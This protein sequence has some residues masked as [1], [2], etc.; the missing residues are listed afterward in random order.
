MHNT[1]DI[2][3]QNMPKFTRCLYAIRRLS[4][5]QTI[6]PSTT[7]VTIIVNKYKKLDFSSLRIFTNI[8]GAV[9]KQAYITLIFIP[10][11]KVAKKN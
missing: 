5:E 9:T 7:A 3:V 8:S 10:K 6:D 4:F 2:K 11:T 1:P